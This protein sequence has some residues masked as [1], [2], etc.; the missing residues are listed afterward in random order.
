M[1]VKLE[2][3][4]KI[5]KNCFIL[6][7]NAVYYYNMKPFV[8]PFLK[9]LFLFLP[10]FSLSGENFRVRKVHSVT[11]TEEPG[12]E[13][14]VTIGINDSIAVFLPEKKDS[15]RFDFLEGL[16]VKVSI[17]KSVSDWRDSVALSLYDGVSPKPSASQIDYSGTRIF[18][19][20]L[21]SKMSWIVQIPLYRETGLK[22]SSYT[23]KVNVIPDVQKGFA[24]LRFMPVMK[25]VPE[26]TLNANLT[27]TIKPCLRNKGRL[28][29]NFERNSE[30]ENT[31]VDILLDDQLVESQFKGKT[32]SVLVNPGLHSVN[33]QSNEFRSEV[34][35]CMVEQ[36]KITQEKF[37]FKSLKPLL[38]VSAPDNAEIFLDGQKLT[39]TGKEFE[40]SEGEHS[41]KFILGSY[42][43]LR[44]ITAEKG[45]TYS[46][47]LN[48][49]LQ[50]LED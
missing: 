7:E 9:A 32:Y 43:V 37:T 6:F 1:A 42:E 31:P 5:I 33:V 49:D 46:A 47:N 3:R 14:S 19:Q 26:E 25:G 16:E 27:V 44:N 34:R 23:T 4:A 8:R 30:S 40:V 11:L 39:E 24:F 35:S 50:I 17:P 41:L 12:F 28:S 21:P 36:A 45:K 10:L 22:D 38:S 29:L 20:P 18:I 48:I 2:I 13:K 15:S